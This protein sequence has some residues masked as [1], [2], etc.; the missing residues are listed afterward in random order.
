MQNIN[1]CNNVTGRGVDYDSG[2]Y[3]VTF[4]AGQTNASFEIPIN[5]DNIYKYSM[6]F[7]LTINHNALL[8]GVA[9]GTPYEARVTIVD[10]EGE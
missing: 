4:P 1:N 10:N 5:N 2:P 7:N 8:D 6:V 9:R 3:S